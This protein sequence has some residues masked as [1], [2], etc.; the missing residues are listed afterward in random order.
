MAKRLADIEKIVQDSNCRFVDYLKV[1]FNK[2]VFDLLDTLS[3]VSTPYIFSGVIRNFFLKI[4]ENRDLD[5]FLDG[6]FDILPIIEG[7]SYKQNSFGG[8]KVS[9]EG[10]NI[11]LW[12]LK[13]TWAIN[14]SQISL[15]MEL[16]RYIP[17]TA[18]FNFSSVI[19]SLNDGRFIYTKHFLRFLRDKQINIVYTPNA[20]YALCIVNTFYYSDKLKLNIGEK[21]RN[22]IKKIASN[23]INYTDQAQEKHFGEILYSMDELKKKIDEL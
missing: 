12:F 14:N 16:A 4:S 13:D 1:N 21:L 17:Q 8:Y 20:N 9:I 19:Y 18:F 22:H 11:D 5:L 2:S 6:D 10:T 3:M 15:D 7:Y 23:N